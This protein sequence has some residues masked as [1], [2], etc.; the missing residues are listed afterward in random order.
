MTVETVR[1]LVNELDGRLEERNIGK[2][3]FSD[4]R[5]TS[6]PLSK[7]NFKSIHKMESDR[8]LVFVDGGNQ[9]VLGAPN[10]SIQINRVYFNVFKGLKR[11]FK[12]SNSI[13]NRVEFFSATHSRFRDSEIYYDT[14]IFPLR[15]ELKELLPEEADLSF[16]SF[17]R[18]VTFG[19]Q[20]ADIS[21]V[22]SIARKF[23]EWEY[24]FHLIQQVM[25]AGDVLVLDGTLQTGFTNEAKYARKVYDAGMSKGVIVT[26]LSKTSHLF[27]TTGLSLLGAVRKLADESNLPFSSWYLPVAETTSTDHNAVILVIKLNPSG[28]HIFRYEIYRDQYKELG[29]SELA[30]ILSQLAENSRDMSFPGYPYGLIDADRFARVTHGEVES[31]RMIFLSEISKGGRW[32]KFARYIHAID[33]HDVLNKLI[34]R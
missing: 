29:E 23:A 33:A 25:K 12:K 26:G 10:F 13:P 18:T 8:A 4:P 9:E 21:R 16:N 24:A 32:S 27:T 11:V 5:Y 7:E 6:F 34:G 1:K 14:I 20:R 3:F 30:E 19:T 28:G 22:A 2:P 17:D 31:Y 15:E